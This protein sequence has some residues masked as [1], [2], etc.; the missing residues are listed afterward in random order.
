MNKD[1]HNN[2]AVQKVQ[3]IALTV[4]DA[5]RS[6]DFYT[7]ALGFET[8]S[9][10][11]V[12]GQDYRDLEQVDSQIRII[13]LQLGDESIK[14]MQY[15]DVESKPIP[16]DSRS[17]D[18]WFQHLAIVV[19]DMDRAY[20]HLRSFPIKP[21]S[22]EPQTIPESN[23]ASAGVKAF[24]FRELD[25]HSL[26]LIWFPPDKGQEKWQQK[27]EHL[28]LGIDHSA[29]SV[30]D[31]EQSLKFYQD[32]LGMEVEG[33]T[34]N[35]GET[36]ALLDGLPGAKV[37]VTSLRPAQGGLG[38]ELL[39]YLV[40][41]DARA[42]PDDWQSCDLAHLQAE[43][44]VNQIENSSAKLKQHG[45]TIVSPGIVEFTSDS[46]PYRQACLLKDPNG[47][48]MLLFTK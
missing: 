33:E 14:L 12:S 7:H 39:H 23:Q 15:L 1:N 41:D 24:K 48:A 42:V 3:A 45:Y 8:V 25:H 5:K 9:D 10:I 40:P 29:I 38:I 46:S 2:L 17:N 28:F 18:L 32:I 43:L 27:S 19:S 44:E 6:Q 31:T 26:E 47:H 11:T 13:T 34:L 4:K 36:Q 30:T 22:T 37:R 20:A 21:I 16:K 35:Q